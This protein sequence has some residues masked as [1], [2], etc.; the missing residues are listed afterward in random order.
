MWFNGGSICRNRSIKYTE[1]YP[2][3]Y[4]YLNVLYNFIILAHK[5]FFKYFIQNEANILH[6]GVLVYEKRS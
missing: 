4:F 2:G 1:I 5:Y 3:I 6:E